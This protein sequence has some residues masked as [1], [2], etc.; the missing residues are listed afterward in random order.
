MDNVKDNRKCFGN[1]IYLIVSVTVYLYVC[2]FLI[3]CLYK[4]FSTYGTEF[5]VKS[6]VDTIF[7]IKTVRR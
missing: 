7:T 3:I 5:D 6:C 4:S 2:I 1:L